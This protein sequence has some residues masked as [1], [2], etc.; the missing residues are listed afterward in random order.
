MLAY[1]ASVDIKA[2]PEIVWGLITDAEKFTNWDPDVTRI[3]GQIV[4]NQKVTV[5]TKVSPDRAF[6]VTVAEFVPNQKMV[7]ASGMPLGMFKGQRTFT[8]TQQGDTTRYHVRE[9]FTGWL[10]PII[11]RTIPD[12]SEA[13]QR[14]ADALK[15]TAEGASE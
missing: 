3:E 5:Y 11:G 6:P 14:H 4:H 9:E 7:W 2:S 8:L 12:L 13:F 10:L 15:A 1:E